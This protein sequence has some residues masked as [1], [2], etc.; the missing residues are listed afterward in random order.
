MLC[1]CTSIPLALLS[2]TWDDPVSLTIVKVPMPMEVLPIAKHVSSCNT[3][4]QDLAIDNNWW[5]IGWTTTMQIEAF[6]VFLTIWPH[7][8][9]AL[10]RKEELKAKRRK[11]QHLKLR[12]RIRFLPLK[13]SPVH[14]FIKKIHNFKK[15]FDSKCWKRPELDRNKTHCIFQHDCC[16]KS[17]LEFVIYRRKHAWDALV[18]S[19][20]ITLF[21]T[22]HRGTP[23]A[24]SSTKGYIPM[25]SSYRGS[26]SN[27][28]VPW[29]K[30]ISP[31]SNPDVPSSI[32]T[33]IVTHLLFQDAKCSVFRRGRICGLARPA[34]CQSWP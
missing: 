19:H 12:S 32:P 14:T 33:Q 5:F 24:D 22:I 18:F 30:F 6:I 26:S 23:S 9:V 7:H 21:A 1:K 11:A 28:S 2:S 17:P 4:F 13:P 16:V 15:D 10:K 27:S 8:F 29:R 34:H 31:A 20:L 25:K 3:S